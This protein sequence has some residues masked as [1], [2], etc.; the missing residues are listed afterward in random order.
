[1]VQK[2]V[3]GFMIRKK[4]IVADRIRKINGPFGWIPHRFISDGYIK[5]F[6]RDE[7]LMYFF[8]SV[9]SDKLGLS[10]YG[11]KTM[12]KLLGINYDDLNSSRTLLQEK[13]FIAYNKPLYQVLSL[14]ELK[15]D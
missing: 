10:Y 3:M 6:T 2:E 11:D 1:M 8:L 15:E 14:P 12:G 5:M 7:L 13:G 9:V 4:L